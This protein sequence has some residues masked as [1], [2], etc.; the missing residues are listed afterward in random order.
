VGDGTGV[1]GLPVA[2]LQA[3]DVLDAKRGLAKFRE[4]PR[5]AS[6]VNMSVMTTLYY[7]CLYHY[8]LSEACVAATV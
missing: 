1:Y 6:L 2:C 5:T 3:A 7:C 4:V 8:D